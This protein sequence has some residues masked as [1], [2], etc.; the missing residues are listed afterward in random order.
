MYD[1]YK[2]KNERREDRKRNGSKMKVSGL[3]YVIQTT[4]MLAKR[5]GKGK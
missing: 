2:T 3:S 5:S 1:E 4:N